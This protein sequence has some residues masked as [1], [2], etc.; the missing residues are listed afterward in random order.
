MYAFSIEVSVPRQH[1]QSEERRI[2]QWLVKQMDK[3]IPSF[4]HPT[5]FSKNILVGSKEVTSHKFSNGGS[6]LAQWRS[7]GEKADTNQ[8]NGNTN[9]LRKCANWPNAVR[10]VFISTA[11]SSSPPV[12]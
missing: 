5:L 10:D 11:G 9:Q 8:N 7:R 2:Y 4:L 1:P 6:A 12:I 3:D